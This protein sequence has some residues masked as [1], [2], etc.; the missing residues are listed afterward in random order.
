MSLLGVTGRQVIHHWELVVASAFGTQ[1]D[2]VAVVLNLRLVAQRRL[3][4]ST[5]G[6]QQEQSLLCFLRFL[7]PF[8]CKAPSEMFR[9]S[10]YVHLHCRFD[11]GTHGGDQEWL[12]P[13]L[14][15]RK[16]AVH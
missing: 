9:F 11:E 16:P 1:A 15:G 13:T 3:D 5:G 7:G 6:G 2:L 12:L 4:L 10:N 8:L 14:S